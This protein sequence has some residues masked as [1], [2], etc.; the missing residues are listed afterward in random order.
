M[1]WKEVNYDMRN[2]PCHNIMWGKQRTK[3]YVQ[4]E[5]DFLLKHTHSF[6]GKILYVKI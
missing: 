5:H 3:F 6:G 4:Y 1:F 2:C